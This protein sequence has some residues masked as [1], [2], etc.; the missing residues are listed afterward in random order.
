MKIL[1]GPPQITSSQDFS[2]LQGESE[3][4]KKLVASLQAENTLHKTQARKVIVTYAWNLIAIA[5]L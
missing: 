2:K 3:K 4:L 1:G 5:A